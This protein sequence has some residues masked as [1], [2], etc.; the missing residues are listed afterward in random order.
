MRW[1][2][3][4]CCARQRLPSTSRSPPWL[5]ASPTGWSGSRSATLR[6]WKLWR[7]TRCTRQKCNGRL[8][9][10]KESTKERLHSFMGKGEFGSA[11]Q[12]RCVDKVTLANDH[13]DIDSL[14]IKQ[15]SLTEVYPRFQWSVRQTV[16]LIKSPWHVFK[17]H[18]W[19]WAGKWLTPPLCL[20]RDKPLHRFEPRSEARAGF[21][22]SAALLNVAG[23]HY[24]RPIR[25][26]FQ[27]QGRN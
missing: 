22:S 2:L 8:R 4:R 9:S 16:F 21:S 18:V 13:S 12:H 10:T 24:R 27:I 11:G 17:T 5:K 23:I 6:S 3:V 1:S 20:L 25:L 15:L 19:S 14:C 26:E 7:K